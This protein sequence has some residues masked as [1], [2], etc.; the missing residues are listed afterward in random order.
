M[1][2]DQFFSLPDQ[3]QG[4]PFWSQLLPAVT[5]CCREEGLVKYPPRQLLS[6]TLTQW[7]SLFWIPFSVSFCQCFCSGQCLQYT[8]CSGRGCTAFSA[9]HGCFFRL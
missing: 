3:L 5:S 2:L 9:A 7:N 6:V 8:C 1:I 4:V